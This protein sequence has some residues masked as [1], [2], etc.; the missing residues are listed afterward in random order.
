MKGICIRNTRKCCV[1]KTKKDIIDETN[2]TL[3]NLKKDTVNQQTE[4]WDQSQYLKDLL[5]KMRKSNKAEELNAVKQQLGGIFKNSQ[6]QQG[7]KI[8]AEQ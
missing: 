4:T 8:A 5:G 7:L 2:E 6:P 1:R 3:D